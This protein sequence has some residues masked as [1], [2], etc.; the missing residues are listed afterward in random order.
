MFDHE[1]ITVVG[2]QTTQLL[3]KETLLS[4]KNTSPQNHYET[5]QLYAVGAL[6]IACVG[7]QCVGFNNTLYRTICA[8]SGKW[9]NTTTEMSTTSLPTG[10]GLGNGA[11][12]NLNVV[13]ES[14]Y[15]KVTESDVKGKMVATGAEGNENA[16]LGRS[17]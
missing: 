6:K 13:G 12:W 15:K 11:I 16:P 3:V 4:R 2:P 9:K 8:Q 10:T 7:L 5:A 17:G 14:T 1:L